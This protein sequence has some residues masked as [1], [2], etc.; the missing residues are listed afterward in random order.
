MQIIVKKVHEECN[1]SQMGDTDITIYC[2]VMD[3]LAAGRLIEK[4]HVKVFSKG[5]CKVPWIGRIGAVVETEAPKEYRGVTEIK[6]VAPKQD[7]GWVNKE[8][9]FEGDPPSTS[10]AT[11]SGGAYSQN[12]TLAEYDALFKQAVQR[13]KAVLDT[14]F[15][16]DYT[17]EAF[18]AL[19]ATYLIGASRSNIRAAHQPAEP[20]VAHQ[21]AKPAVVPPSESDNIPF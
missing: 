11:P 19:A 4:A 15:G 3:V 20:V 1:P 6:V 7:N 17:T 5:Q 12:Y 16:S 21:P 18:C 13:S 8:P 10:R 14:F 9:K 2:W